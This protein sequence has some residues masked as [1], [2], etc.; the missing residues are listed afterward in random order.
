MTQFKDHV[1]FS[2]TND[3]DILGINYDHRDFPLLYQYLEPESSPDMNGEM[4]SRPQREEGNLSNHMET[5]I[6]P[7][8]GPEDLM[9]FNT[10]D[11]LLAYLRQ[12]QPTTET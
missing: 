4:T 3:L 10:T 9:Y 2:D 6:P 7:P 8:Q 11:E 1:S 5:Y 12:I